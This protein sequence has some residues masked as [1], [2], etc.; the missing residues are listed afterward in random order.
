MSGLEDGAK[1]S[2][3]L[4]KESE[5]RLRLALDS[6]SDGAWDWNVRSGEVFYSDRWIQSLGYERRDVRPRITFWE[7]RI[8]PEDS[9][10]VWRALTPHLDGA[11]ERFQCEYRLRL[12]SGGYRWTLDRGRVVAR[13]EAGKALRMVGTN[14]DVTEQHR[15]AERLEAAARRYRLLFETARSP[16]VCLEPGGQIAEFNPAAERLFGWRREQ[17]LGT[18]FVRCYLPPELQ[19]RATEFIERI[20]R[21]EVTREFATSVPTDDGRLRDLLWTAAPLRDISGELLVVAVGQDIT[22]RK[23]LERR[24][25]GLTAICSWCKQ[26]RTEDGDW[27]P[28]EDYISERSRALFSHGCCPGCEDHLETL[29]TEP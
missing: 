11:T 19:R 16:I 7:E 12:A 17:V 18:D 29:A 10:S 8:H 26:I 24:L 22:E 1:T 21:D 20:E 23:R 28:L 14:C 5:E 25:R 9:E 27:L 3:Q 2:A 15:A 6:V 4:L 13:D